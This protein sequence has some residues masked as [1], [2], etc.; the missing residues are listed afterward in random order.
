MCF[1]FAP[2]AAVQVLT[3]QFWVQ[4]RAYKLLGRMGQLLAVQDASGLV[5]SVEI[6][7]TTAPSVYG[8][9]LTPVGEDR[10]AVGYADGQNPDFQARV[11]VTELP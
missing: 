2:H 4:A 11:L 8:V 10:V 5:A 9:D 7:T 1:A 3:A 6:P